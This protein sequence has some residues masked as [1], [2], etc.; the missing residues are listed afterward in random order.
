M[1]V[2]DLSPPRRAWRSPSPRVRRRASSPA[3]AHRKEPAPKALSRAASSHFRPTS[4]D[5][6]DSTTQRHRVRRPETSLPA[7]VCQGTPRRTVAP[8]PR[9]PRETNFP[10]QVQVLDC[11]SP[12]V[13]ASL[14]GQQ[15]PSL[16]C[17]RLSQPSTRV[18]R[19]SCLVS[20]CA[21]WHWGCTGSLNEVGLPGGVV[22]ISRLVRLAHKALSPAPPPPC[23]AWLLSPSLHLVGACADI[24]SAQAHVRSGTS[25]LHTARAQGNCPSYLAWGRA[26]ETARS[27]GGPF[28]CVCWLDLGASAPAECPPASRWLSGP[29]PQHCRM[30]C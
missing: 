6:T 24:N 1:P 14:A 22:H 28:L 27:L 20:P 18:V 13:R 29:A 16:P 4:A 19:L 7:A 15:A 5:D 23:M 11:L 26:H 25:L 21:F 3:D 8:T 12:G 10:P 17:L 2:P 30:P 9:C